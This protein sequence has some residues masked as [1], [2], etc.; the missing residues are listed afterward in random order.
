GEP[1]SNHMGDFLSRSSISRIILSGTNRRYVI[2]SSVTTEKIMV[3][4]HLY[5]KQKGLVAS[6]M[7]LTLEAVSPISAPAPQVENPVEVKD[8]VYD[9]QAQA[10]R[11]DAN[12]AESGS[13]SQE[14]DLKQ[15]ALKKKAIKNSMV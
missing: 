14:N 5:N 7:N 15:S 4:P 6:R 8:L 2:Q 3:A 10:K 1:A 9:Y 11:S 12:S 13:A